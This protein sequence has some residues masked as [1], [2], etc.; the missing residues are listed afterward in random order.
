M[1]R[2]YHTIRYRCHV[3]HMRTVVRIRNNLLRMR[4]AVRICN[5]FVTLRIRMCD[6]CAL[7]YHLR[8]FPIKLKFNRH[9]NTVPGL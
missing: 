4:T 1:V 9:M 2:A 7:T 6:I 3:L 8:L 5:M